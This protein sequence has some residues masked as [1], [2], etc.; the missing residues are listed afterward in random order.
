MLF[1]FY[2]DSH[3][4]FPSAVSKLDYQ[5]RMCVLWPLMENIQHLLLLFA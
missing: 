2:G 4:N 1:A 3:R 5:V